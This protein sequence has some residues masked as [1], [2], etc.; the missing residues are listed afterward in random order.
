MK[1]TLTT[2]TTITKSPCGCSFPRWKVNTLT[3][4]INHNHRWTWDILHG[5][6]PKLT[7]RQKF[8]RFARRIENFLGGI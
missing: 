2:L 3:W 5:P 1:T 7:A 4:L 6:I 8:D